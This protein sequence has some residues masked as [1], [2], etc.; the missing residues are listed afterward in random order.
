MLSNLY[1]YI[2]SGT[3]NI[4]SAN[5]NLMNMKVKHVHRCTEPHMHKCAHSHTHT[6]TRC[7]GDALTSPSGS[8]FGQT[9]RI[10]A[11]TMLTSNRRCCLSLSHTHSTSEF[12]FQPLY[13]SVALLYLRGNIFPTTLSEMTFLVTETRT[14]LSGHI[15]FSLSHINAFK[16]IK[17]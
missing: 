7:Q 10:R 13:S 9:E 12:P 11:N 2:T 1:M 14:D 16:H 6:H 3:L 4:K 5:V 8:R 15:L 17:H